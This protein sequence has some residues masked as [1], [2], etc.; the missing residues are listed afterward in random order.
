[1]DEHQETRERNETADRVASWPAGSS[2]PQVALS[3]VLVAMEGLFHPRP[4]C[5]S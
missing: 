1:M 3:I 4:L 2:W 5:R